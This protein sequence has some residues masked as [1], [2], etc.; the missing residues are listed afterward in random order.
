MF[1]RFNSQDLL[2]WIL[3][4]QTIPEKESFN[5]STICHILDGIN[6]NNAPDQ[7]PPRVLKQCVPELTPVPGK[8]D[9]PYEL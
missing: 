3:Q 8:Y 7:I 6:V 4:T 2:F 5:H 9:N 1:H